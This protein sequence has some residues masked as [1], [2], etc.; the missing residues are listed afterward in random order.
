MPTTTQISDTD[1]APPFEASP[2]IVTEPVYKQLLRLCR[3]MIESGEFAPDA[4]FPSERDLA[5]RYGVSRATANKVI[6][7]LVA[8]QM[9]LLKPGLGAFVTGNKSLHAS[10]REMESF[11]GHVEALGLSA[12]TKVLAFKSLNGAKL[13]TL[14]ATELQATP[15]A[16]YFYI[17]RLRIADDEPVILE[18]RWL[19]AASFP[20]L[21]EADLQGSFYAL[22]EGRYGIRLAG[23]NHTIRARN[24][25]DP[26][27]RKLACRKDAAALE[28]EGPGFS[29]EGKVLWYQQLLYRGDRYELKNDA[30]PNSNRAATSVVLR[31]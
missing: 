21:K 1:T 15:D 20:N 26:D 14:V 24:L 22:L 31:P 12:S 6:N 8:E 5:T 13:P 18:R 29:A 30:R 27:A 9:L 2:L 4:Q 23:E 17:E 11:T 3:K 16:D 10:L 28:V 19:A 7:H 25:D